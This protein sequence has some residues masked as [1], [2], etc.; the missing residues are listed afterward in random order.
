MKFSDLPLKARKASFWLGGTLSAKAAQSTTDFD[1]RRP[2]PA[3]ETN[4]YCDN[5]LKITETLLNKR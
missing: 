4:S 2:T 5:K 1:N 3:I